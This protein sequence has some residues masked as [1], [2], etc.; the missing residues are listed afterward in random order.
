MAM[1]PYHPSS[2]YRPY[3]ASPLL[4][5]SASMGNEVAVQVMQ[6]PS[7]VLLAYSVSGALTVLT[8]V[9]LTHFGGLT[10]G[11]VGLLISAAV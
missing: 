6:A 4:F 9:G 8:G 5:T 7:E 11:L 3:G 1:R 2:P 10:G